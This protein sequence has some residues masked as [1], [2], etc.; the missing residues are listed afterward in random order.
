[1]VM[2]LQGC[3]VQVA[4]LH[5]GVPQAGRRVTCSRCVPLC[6]RCR[7]RGYAAAAPHPWTRQAALQPAANS[8]RDG[9]SLAAPTSG[10]CG[11]LRHPHPVPPWWS[12]GP[13]EATQTQLSAPLQQQ[14]QQQ[15]QQRRHSSSSILASNS[16]RRPAYSASRAQPARRQCCRGLGKRA[17]VQAQTRMSELTTTCRIT[18][19]RLRHRTAGTLPDAPPY[20]CHSNSCAT[21]QLALDQLRHRT[22]GSQPAHLKVDDNGAPSARRLHIPHLHAG[23]AASAAQRLA[24]ERGCCKRASA[25]VGIPPK[26]ASCTPDLAPS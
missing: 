26:V 25:S 4:H 17:S 10:T 24:S 5:A 13:A 18:P 11:W 19:S 9:I 23:A 8:C 7:Q 14:Q 1:M 22:A 20:S 6:S 2:L 12:Y 21:V 16:Q 15:Q 3:E